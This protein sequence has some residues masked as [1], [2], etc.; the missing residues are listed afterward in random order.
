MNELTM[1]GR[2]VHPLERQEKRRYLM[3]IA[4]AVI[5]LLILFAYPLLGMVWRSVESP[6]GFTFAQYIEVF[7]NDIYRSVLFI[8][9]RISAVAAVVC[10]ILGYPVAYVLAH[11][12]PRTARLMMIAIILPYF[13]SVIVRTFAWVVILGRQGIVNLWLV[14]LG[15]VGA[16]V[17][18]LYREFAVILG[19]TYV[20][21]PFMILTNYT[22]MRGIDQRYMR[23]AYSLGASK[24]FVFRRIFLPLSLPGVWG[25][26]LLVFILAIG[27]FITP[28]LMGGSNEMTVSMLIER[29]VEITL[30]WAFASAIATVLLVVTLLVFVVYA[31]LV[32]I[33]SLLGGH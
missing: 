32:K 14:S 20:L 10:V 18:L 7:T 1:R 21:L 28:A 27:F 3:M 30:N 12:K 2:F 19:M 17:D 4:P 13:T 26:V 8:T 23:A 5:M 16:P 15:L 24:F 9:F 11:A 29:E 22:V 25:G 6:A 33:K 31:R